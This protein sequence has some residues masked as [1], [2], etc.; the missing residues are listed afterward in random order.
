[1]NSDVEISDCVHF[2][3]Y[4]CRWS[5]LVYVWSLIYKIEF[6][7][8]LILIKNYIIITFSSGFIIKNKILN[9]NV[10]DT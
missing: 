3:I 7:F 5:T 10:I 9:V 1:M 4:W 6:S 8:S 2:S